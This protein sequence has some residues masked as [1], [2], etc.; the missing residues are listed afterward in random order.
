MNILLTNDDGINA[1]GLQALATEFC[2]LGSVTVLAPDHNWSASGH[3]KTLHRPIRV[4]PVSF[5]DGIE[6]YSSDGAPSDCVAL[7]ML[8]LLNK[9]FDLVISGIN[10]NANLG[11]D[12]T[13][14]G[15]VTAAMEAVIWGVYGIAVSLENK[16]IEESKRNYLFAAKAARIVTET[17]LRKKLPKD[18]LLNINVPDIPEDQIRGFMFTRQGQ[19]IYHDELVRKT[20]PRGNPYYW[21]GGKAPTGIEE[22]GT[23]I[24]GLSQ[25]FVTITPLKMDMTNY[26]Q[27]NKMKSWKP[28]I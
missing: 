9:S 17:V 6:A 24:G 10:S 26:E 18:T 3:V 22:D 8:G 25:N 12:V 16:G 23:D 14:S 2:K 20:D 11:H 1:P 28:E 21:I 27:L 5:I 4:T 7:A 15:T 13:Y 19:R